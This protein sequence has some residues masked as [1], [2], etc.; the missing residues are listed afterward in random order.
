MG[1]FTKAYEGVRVDYQDFYL[2][3]PREMT[4][5]PDVQQQVAGAYGQIGKGLNGKAV[6]NLNMAVREL[7][8]EGLLGE[9]RRLIIVRKGTARVYVYATAYG[10]DLFASMATYFVG[11]IT[12]SKWLFIG[13]YIGWWSFTNG[14]RTVLDLMRNEWNE[15]Q[16]DDVSAL[17]DSVHDSLTTALD[18]IGQGLN[19]DDEV[20][21]RAVG[22]AARPMVAKGRYKKA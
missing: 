12:W 11:L 7:K 6:P 21:A 10:S 8:A 22:L 15:F 3:I 4:A 9:R 5:R 18:E 13:V 20:L 1:M 14:E 2:P 16:I 19:L 17:A